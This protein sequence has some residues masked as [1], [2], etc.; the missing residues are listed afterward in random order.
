MKEVIY[1][2]KERCS[3][4][5]WIRSDRIGF[6]WIGFEWIGSDLIGLDWIGFDSE[7]VG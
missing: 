7:I 2:F 4:L 6:E 3:G 5:D 1:G